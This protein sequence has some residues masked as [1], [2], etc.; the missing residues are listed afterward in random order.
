MPRFLAAPIP[1][2]AGTVNASN[3]RDNRYRPSIIIDA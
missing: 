2:P 1:G 3:R